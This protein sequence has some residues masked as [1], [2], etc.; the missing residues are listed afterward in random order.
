MSKDNK[1]VIEAKPFSRAKNAVVRAASQAV[2]EDGPRAATL[3]N[4]AGRAGITEPAIFRHFDGVDGLF[5]GLYQTVDAVGAAFEASFEAALPPIHRLGRA[6]RARIELF[7][8][9]ADLAYLCVYQRQIFQAYPELR[10]R[11]D[12]REKTEA[13]FVESCLREAQAAGAFRVEMALAS[14]QALT[15]GAVW[16][17]VAGWSSGGGSFDLVGA[18]D[19]LWADFIKAAAPHSAPR[20]KT[21][22][23]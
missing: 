16:A 4:V 10:A 14:L 15:A 6:F 19:T 13:A 21:P 8:R 11:M 20:K 23:A 9:D 18:F 3:K 7:S 12:S 17:M 2:R 22:K 5:G 1:Q